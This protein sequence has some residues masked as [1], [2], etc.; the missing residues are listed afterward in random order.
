VEIDGGDATC[1]PLSYPNR[2]PPMQTTHPSQYA[3]SLPSV[4]FFI[5]RAVDLFGLSNSEDRKKEK[6]W[7]SSQDNA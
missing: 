7:L 5:L 2:N 1:I 3:R 4:E 6:A